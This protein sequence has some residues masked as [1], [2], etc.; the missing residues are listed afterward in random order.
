MNKKSAIIFFLVLVS[1]LA[2]WIIESRK[3]ENPPELIVQ[4][5]Q[6]INSDTRIKSFV[7]NHSNLAV[8]VIKEEVEPAEY[9][10]ELCSRIEQLGGRGIA[11]QVVDVLKL[12]K[13]GGEDWEEIGYAKCQ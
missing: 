11:V 8:G 5:N 10:R 1:V 13:S 12:Q 3:P 4:M 9:A 7:W 6:M 2:T